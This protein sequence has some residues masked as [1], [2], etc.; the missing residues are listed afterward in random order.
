MNYYIFNPIY[1]ERV[2]GGTRF[3][4]DL[5]RELPEG[6][7]IGESWEIVD[8]V[9]AQ[10]TTAEGSTIRELITADP[11]G[12][13]GANWPAEKPFPILVKWL[14]CKEKLSLQVHPPADVAHR[15]D[16]EPKTEFWYIAKADP[17][18]T[19]MA[20]LKNGVTYEEFETALK[21]DT[22]E[23]LIHTL[24]VSAGESIFIPSGRIH[25]IGGGNLILEIQQNSDT[26]Y[27]V[28]DWGRVGLD[29]TPRELHIQ[30]S[31]ES[32]D[33]QDYEPDTLKAVSG[34]QLLAKSDVF[35][36][37]KI[38]LKAGE[39]LTFDAGAPRILSLISGSLEEADGSSITSSSNALL[40]A[41][42]SFDFLAT[43]NS[44]LLLTENFT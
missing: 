3:A 34:N 17:N 6:K 44:E 10:S 7:I 1:Q 4:T 29:G 39:H 25:A 28:Y 19:L 42:H 30:E 36:L 12:I 13:M 32:Y 2:W 43:E 15:L 20:G 37:Q 26:T 8:R 33:F 41:A 27:R 16:G 40:P 11:E 31:L 35:D 23:P 18:A 9:E 22:L 21:K 5:G 38:S 14:D 24:H